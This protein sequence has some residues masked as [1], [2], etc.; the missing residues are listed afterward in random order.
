MLSDPSFRSAFVFSVNS[1]ILPGCRLTSFYLAE[2]SLSGF[3]RFMLLRV[4]LFENITKC[5]LFIIIIIQIFSTHFAVNLFYL[6]SLKTQSM[7]QQAQRASERT[8]SKQK[9]N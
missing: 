5:L 1:L 7:E 3:P 2:A 8:K 6:H 4:Q 9:Q